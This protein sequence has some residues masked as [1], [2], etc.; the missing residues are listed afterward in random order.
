MAA[1]YRRGQH[2]KHD[3]VPTITALDMAR[4]WRL[5]CVAKRCHILLMEKPASTDRSSRQTAARPPA[6]P[7]DPLPDP[8]AASPPPAEIGGPKGPEPTRFGDWQ[9][10][11]R[12]TDF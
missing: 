6:P 11:G 7:P 10:N 8:L 3:M 2:R 5:G 1:S 12:C 9:Y 4:R